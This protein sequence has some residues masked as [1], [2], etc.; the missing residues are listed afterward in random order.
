VAC[1][2]DCSRVPGGAPCQVRGAA[3][4]ARGTGAGGGGAR[5]G[6]AGWDRSQLLWAQVRPP[7][8]P[9]TSAP[10]AA[11]PRRAFALVEDTWRARA[12]S[13]RRGSA[14]AGRRA[15]RRRSL[16]SVAG[17][18]C[19]SPPATPTHPVACLSG[20]AWL[21]GARFVR[22]HSIHSLSLSLSLSLHPLPY[23]PP[24]TAADRRPPRA[25]TTGTC[26]QC[27]RR[28][29]ATRAGASRCTS[30]LRTKAYRSRPHPA[31]RARACRDPGQARRPR[32]AARS[33]PQR[34]AARGAAAARAERGGGGRAWRQAP[35]LHAL[36]RA[37]PRAPLVADA[38]G[39]L[40]LHVLCCNPAVPF[41]PFPSVPFPP[42]PSVPFP[43]FPFP[44]S[45]QPFQ[46]RTPAPGAP[47]P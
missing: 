5:R 27:P 28:A 36:L 15:P 23:R 20:L 4:R 33:A 3:A 19:P 41:P 13:E 47:A 10:T 24:L 17:R 43:P 18:P 32:R 1:T 9:H 12:A 35:V 22:G 34:P 8:S 6:G 45:L 25:A 39:R 2:L 42:F 37:Y 40:P 31:S 29:R 26:D 11:P 30:C 7:L 38:E 14:A 16:R 44:E 21:L 46:W